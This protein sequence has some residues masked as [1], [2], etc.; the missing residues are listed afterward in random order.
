[1]LTPRFPGLVLSWMESLPSPAKDCS[2]RLP[3]GSCLEPVSLPV[4][5]ACP[6]YSLIHFKGSQRGLHLLKYDLIV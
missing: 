5:I 6:V 1:M 4:C 2:H 3:K